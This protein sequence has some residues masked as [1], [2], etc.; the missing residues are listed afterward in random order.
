MKPLSGY[1]DNREKRSTEY[2]QPLQL[3]ST[4]PLAPPP[5]SLLHPDQRSS[6]QD[7]IP[8]QEVDDA[9]EAENPL[10]YL[11]PNQREAAMENL[12][13]EVMDRIQKLRASIN[14]LTSSLQFRGEAELNR[15][16]AVVR[17]MTMEEFCFKYN[18]SAKEYLQ[19]QTSSKS[20][21]DTAFLH[22]MGLTHSKRKRDPAPQSND[23]WR[24]KRPSREDHA[25]ST[26]EAAL[27]SRS[28]DES[29]TH[30]VLGTRSQPT[31]QSSSNR[32]QANPFVDARLSLRPKE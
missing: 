7:S 6:K 11:T 32:H 29:S 22:A 10:I 30:H 13:I 23:F 14:V 20:V 17:S 3:Q 26:F 4:I 9:E 2:Y 24:Y 18:G 1:K 16:P 19:R 21:A 12:E 25:T 28:T 31:S 5:M 8:G 15:L 27:S